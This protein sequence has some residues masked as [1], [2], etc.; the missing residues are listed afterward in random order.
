[1]IEC[2]GELNLSGVGLPILP[3]HL[4]AVPGLKFRERREQYSKIL[5][6]YSYS[7]RFFFVTKRGLAFLRETQSSIPQDCE[8]ELKAAIR[9]TVGRLTR[10][11]WVREEGGQWQ[12]F[13]GGLFLQSELDRSF[14]RRFECRAEPPGKCF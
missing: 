7:A 2:T 11:H 13:T 8:R 3:G 10:F 4:I 5:K 9:A 14:G 1:M 12:A 6:S